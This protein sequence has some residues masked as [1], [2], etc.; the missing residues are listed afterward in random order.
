MKSYS[1]YKQDEY[2]LT[3]FFKDKRNGTFVDIG[4]HD[5]VTISNTLLFEEIGWTGICVE[6]L[7]KIFKQ[8]EQNRKCKCI[9]GVISDK[10]ES[11]VEFCAIEGY[12]EMLSGILDNYD[13]RHKNRILHESNAH[14]C[15]RQKLK[16]PNF[17]FNDVVDFNYINLLDID[18]EG[19]ELEILK[20]IDY[21]RY[22]IDL[23][24]VEN[25]YNTN[26]IPDFLISKE[27]KY[28]TTLGCDQLFKRAALT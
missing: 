14:N 7:P 12:S 25:N 22:T 15:T 21:D 18:T 3:N 27:F 6:P 13:E 28:V 5:G 10:D 4:A 24:L 11:H 23:I 16:I 17:K 9:N 2:I 26:D 19:S 20:T 8:L 1:Q